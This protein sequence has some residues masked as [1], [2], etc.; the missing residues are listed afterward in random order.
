MDIIKEIEAARGEMASW[1]Q[2]LHEN[3]EI[4]YEE[5]DTSDF[6]AEKLE[7]FGIEVHRGLG[8]TGLVGVIHGKKGKAGAGKAIGLRA[9]MDALP[10]EEE[11]NLPYASKRP[12]RMHACGHD[13]HTTMLLGAAKHLAENRDF[14]GTV[15]CIFQPAEEGGAGA[16]AMMD[17]GLFKKFKMESVWGVHNMPGLAL[18]RAIAHCGPAMAGAD[19]YTINIEGKGGHAAHPHDTN[20][21]VIAA[22][23]TVTALQTLVSRKLDPFDQAVISI[24]MLNAGSASNII[25]ETASITGTLRTMQQDTRKRLISE[26]KSVAKSVAATQGC[27]ASVDLQEGYPP[28][29]NHEAEALFARDVITGMLG[30]DGVDTKATPVM[31]AEDFA[32]MLEEKK[33]AY[34][35]LGAGEDEANLHSPHYDFNDDL[36]P[37]G[38]SFWVRLAKAK[39]AA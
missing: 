36:L 6:V 37:V 18:G 21:P 5:K 30:K 23:L 19:T 2:H 24:T 11:T 25:P 4:C 22:A 8:V 16:K 7:S 17:D 38:A 3:P 9:D 12:G 26:I 34:I 20:D 27:T 28:T 29:F 10:M 1:R 31:G 35:M 13:G 32:F 39:L 14:E 33:G 15:Y